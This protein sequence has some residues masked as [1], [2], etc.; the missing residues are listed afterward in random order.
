MKQEPINLAEKLSRFS[1]HW[2]PKIVAQTNDYHFKLVKFRGEFVWH[3]HISTDEVFIVLEG[4]MTIH[5]RDGDVAVRQGEMFVVPKPAR[6]LNL[7][8]HHGLTIAPSTISYQRGAD[9][10]IAMAS[11]V[12]KLIPFFTIWIRPFILVD[13]ESIDGVRPKPEHAGR[14]GISAMYPPSLSL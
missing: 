3:K 2:P 5:F 1:E 9:H 12:P 14:S 11:T 4:S 6:H 8:I 7:N 10:E 13:G